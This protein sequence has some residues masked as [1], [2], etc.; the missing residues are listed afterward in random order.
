MSAPGTAR[1]LPE[2]PWNGVLVSATV[3]SQPPVQISGT[4]SATGNGATWNVPNTVVQGLL[5]R[6]PTGAL[7]TGNTPIFLVDNGNDRLYADN[8]RTQI[9]MRFAKVLRFSGR[10]L[11]VGMDL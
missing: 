9:D 8:R 6:L 10:R 5:G 4:L 2:I 11:D 7:I 3:R 1:R